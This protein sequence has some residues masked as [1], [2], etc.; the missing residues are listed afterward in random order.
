MFPTNIIALEIREVSVL[1]VGVGPYFDL[2][3]EDSLIEIYFLSHTY[4]EFGK[5]PLHLKPRGLYV[6]LHNYKKSNKFSPIS[7]QI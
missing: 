2:A 1:S 5:R 7:N 6:V 4:L 3:D